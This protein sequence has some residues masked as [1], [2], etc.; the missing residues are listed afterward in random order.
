MKWWMIATLALALSGCGQDSSEPE[1][2]E[3]GV[4]EAYTDSQVEALE[5]ARGVEDELKKADEARRKQLE[6]IQ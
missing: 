4:F 2:A 3:K 5:K 1:V 6:Q